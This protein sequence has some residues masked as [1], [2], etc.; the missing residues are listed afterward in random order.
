M[1]L[2]TYDKG[3]GPRCG[4]LR[5]DQVVDV[6]DL[7]GISGDPLRD[8]RALLEQGNSPLDRVRDALARNTSA[9]STPVADVQLRAPILQPPTVRDFIVYEEHASSQG[10]REPNEV[11]YRM[12]V[13]YFSNP[14]CIYGTDSQIPFPSASSQFDYELEIGCVIGKEGR[15][16]AAADAMNYIA[17]FMLFNDWSARDLQVDEMAFGLGPAKGKDTASSIGPWLVTTDEMAPYLKDGR[18]DLRCEVRVNGRQ[19]LKDGAAIDAYFSFADMVERASKDSRIVPGD[20]IGS[21][22]VGGGS[23]REAIRK[24]YPGARFLEPGDVVEHEVE[25]IGVLRGTIGPK[26]ELDPA[27]RFTVKN[28]SPVPEAGISKDYKYKR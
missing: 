12:P 1:K 22:T 15:D 4:V 26:P 3:A 14:L 18:L 24:G 20:V 10:T 13:F 8:V 2:L 19:W 16:V 25:A 23:I 27:Y 28:P 5:D 11:W 17:G 21:G 9:S 6:S 7:A